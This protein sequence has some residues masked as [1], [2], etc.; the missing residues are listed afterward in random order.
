[1]AVDELK[2]GR[3]VLCRHARSSGG[4]RIYADRP[5]A[6][7]DW[8]CAWLLGHPAFLES[9]RPD[10]TG[11]VGSLA[12]R[13]EVHLHGLD[14]SAELVDRIVSAG[15]TAVVLQGKR[16]SAFG[17]GAAEALRLHARAMR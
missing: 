14:P 15:G 4:C 13:G 7:R 11:V 12:A 8:S 6:C 1:M 10:A 17:P 2:K 5:T 3:G 9:D 16:A